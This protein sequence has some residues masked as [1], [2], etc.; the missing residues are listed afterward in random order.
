MERSAL[1]DAIHRAIGEA[2]VTLRPDV[3]TA[4]EGAMEREDSERGR[5][6][7]RQLLDNAEVARTDSV[8]VCQDTGTAW[9]R[10]TLPED[11]PVPAD[12]QALAD[13]A[14]ARAYRDFG[15]RASTVRDALFDR[16]NPG[17]NTP[18]FLDV[19]FAK[20]A[21]ARVEVMLKG[22]GSDNASVL[23]MLPPSAGSDGVR[24]VVLAAVESKAT[25]AC[26]PLVIG[27]GVGGTFDTV[28]GLA[29]KALLRP[30]GS[31]AA[32]EDAA[33]LERELLDAV[34]ATGIGPAGLGGATT[35]LAVHIVTA[36]CHIAAL[37][38]A[39]NMGCC[40][41]RSAVVEVDG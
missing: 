30:V 6:V 33:R 36:P 2:A 20:R 19:S 23:A 28:A 1:A 31:P 38:V 27:V 35:A 4:L 29:K 25:G 5:A 21:G 8:P 39:V 10:I 11:T 16:S 40:A 41:M 26:P 37:P 34:N 24:D 15:L 22:G 13:G 14:V 18:A 7:I 9:V 32:G 3:R 17:D 12:L